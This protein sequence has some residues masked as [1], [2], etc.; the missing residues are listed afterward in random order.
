MYKPM[1]KNPDALASYFHF[2]VKTEQDEERLFSAWWA[3]THDYKG[4]GVMGCVAELLTA[5][6][7]SNKT[8]I[9]NPGKVDCFVKL[10]TESGHVVPVAVERKTNGGRV[11]TVESELS[12]A[13][14]MVGRYVVYSMDV[15]NSTTSGLRRRVPA[16][17]I[18]RE[19]FLSKLKE[20]N[21]IKAVRHNGVIDGYAIQVSNKRW[22]EWLLD[23]PV[24]YDRDAVYSDDDFEGLE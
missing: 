10:R 22:Y 13:E 23:W 21:A 17:V 9:S 18:P 8:T 19:L 24:V 4:C 6:P 12:K 7:N 1:F 16:V 2:T 5:T 3:Y 15:C 20:F 14:K 11:Q